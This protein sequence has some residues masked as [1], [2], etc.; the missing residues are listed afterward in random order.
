QSACQSGGSPVRS[1]SWF[2]SLYALTGLGYELPATLPNTRLI[3]KTQSRKQFPL[4]GFFLELSE[5][6]GARLLARIDIRAEDP[7]LLDLLGAGG[8]QIIKENDPAR[9]LEIGK[10]PVCMAEQRLRRLL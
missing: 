4:S 5:V 10:P 9:R 8:R 2:L 1:H 3:F 6:I 7:R